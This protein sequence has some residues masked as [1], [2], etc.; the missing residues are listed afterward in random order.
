MTEVGEG[1]SERIEKI[2]LKVPGGKKGVSR[3]KSEAEVGR[4]HGS[5][6]LDNRIDPLHFD[7]LY[8]E[9]HSPIFCI[10]CGF[11]MGFQE[12]PLYFLIP[13]LQFVV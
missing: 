7:V 8:H 9:E 11:L 3:I 10:G 2:E 6:Q 12:L 5:H 4:V 13:A 1:F